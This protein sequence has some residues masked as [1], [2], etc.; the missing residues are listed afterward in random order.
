MLKVRFLV[1]HMVASEKQTKA[2]ERSRIRK[3]LLELYIESS[4]KTI[5]AYMLLKLHG[6][7]SVAAA[8]SR[9]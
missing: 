8:F 2:G 4:A 9:Y 5:K 7:M 6:L 3:K 1:N